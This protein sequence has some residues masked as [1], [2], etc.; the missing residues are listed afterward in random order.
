MK[1]TKLIISVI[2]LVSAFTNLV[3]AQGL[4]LNGSVSGKKPCKARS[5]GGEGKPI[6][7]EPKNI[8]SIFDLKDNIKGPIKVFEDIDEAKVP[9]VDGKNMES[10]NGEF[11]EG[12]EG[13]THCCKSTQVKMSGGK[14]EV[15]CKGDQGKAKMRGGMKGGTKGGNVAK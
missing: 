3:V 12:A 9:V 8:Y 14:P 11:S 2:V 15:V 13:E 7:K 1:K 6:L 4:P 5:K 10:M